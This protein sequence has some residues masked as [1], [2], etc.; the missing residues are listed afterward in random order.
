ML[1]YILKKKI[2]FRISEIELLIYIMVVRILVFD[3]RILRF[4]NPKL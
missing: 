4:Y 1:I 2:I 3:L